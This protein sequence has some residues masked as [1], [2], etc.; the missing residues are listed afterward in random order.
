MSEVNLFNWRYTVL[1]K[2]IWRKNKYCIRCYRENLKTDNFY[3]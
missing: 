2:E 1:D 3:Y